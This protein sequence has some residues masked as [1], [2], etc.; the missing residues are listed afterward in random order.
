MDAKRVG[1]VLYRIGL[2]SVDPEEHEALN[3]AL[4]AIKAQGDAVAFGWYVSWD[5]CGARLYKFLRDEDEAQRFYT[6]NS[7]HDSEITPLYT[8]PGMVKGV[9]GGR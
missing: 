4:A 3:M 8:A 9:D 7:A 6:E 2:K 1:V 5:C